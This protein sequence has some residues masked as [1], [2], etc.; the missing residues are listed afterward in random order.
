M[1]STTKP[2]S[3]NEY[4]A[5][6]PKETQLKLTELRELIKHQ[7]P[8]AEETISYNM[9]AFTI[10]G[11]RVIYFAGWKNHISIYP[12]YEEMKETIKGTQAYETSGKGTIQFPLNEPLPIEIIK[13]MIEFLIA[14]QSK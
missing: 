9:P 8:N 1:Q 10:N 7:L 6:F 13:K 2:T 5:T 11:E 14:K 12:F 3:V 4:I